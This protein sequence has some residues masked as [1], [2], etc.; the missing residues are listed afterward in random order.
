MRHV[1]ILFCTTLSVGFK[2]TFEWGNAEM[3]AK[4]FQFE[5]KR[6]GGTDGLP[7]GRL[8][9]SWGWRQNRSTWWRDNYRIQLLS[10]VLV[11]MKLLALANENSCACNIYT[12]YK[13]YLFS[14]EIVSRVCILLKIKSTTPSWV[15]NPLSQETHLQRWRA[16]PV[17]KQKTYIE[18]HG[19]IVLLAKMLICCLSQTYTIMYGIFTY[20]YHQHEPNVGKYIHHTWIL[21][22]ILGW[23][24]HLLVFI[25]SCIRGVV[26]SL[27]SM[28]TTSWRSGLIKV[29]I[30]GIL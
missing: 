23:S 26:H 27:P 4:N 9:L 12:K 11:Y 30:K 25:C 10:A 18:R 21:W 2:N 1:G 20:I 3:V 22:E 6:R 17:G 7:V 28:R 19:S 13:T 14:V 5:F 29:M 16:K 15:P 8:E 24:V